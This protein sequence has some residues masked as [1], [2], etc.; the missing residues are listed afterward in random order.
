MIFPVRL[1]FCAALCVASAVA[2]SDCSS[3]E[4]TT[5]RSSPHCR[6]VQPDACL[7]NLRFFELR[8][9]GEKDA[10]S[11]WTCPTEGQGGE[12]PFKEINVGDSL[13]Y[14]PLAVFADLSGSAA[15]DLVV[16]DELGQMHYFER[17][18]EPGDPAAYEERCDERTKL[19]WLGPNYDVVGD[20]GVPYCAT[21]G[22]GSSPLSGIHAGPYS[23]PAFVDL[24][25]D[26]LVD[27]L[28]T[29]RFGLI[30][31]K[32][33]DKDRR[34]SSMQLAQLLRRDVFLISPRAQS[35]RTEVPLAPRTS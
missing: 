19:A 35:L 17:T 23:Q 6:H 7:G 26:G 12:N 30:H 15:L 32:C 5:F 22:S 21:E 24:N 2:T 10:D 1:L 20:S 31:C 18:S 33:S 16:T 4:E 13:D 29:D 14:P 27:L 34:Q 3:A 8:C 28:V 11:S 9:D 25:S